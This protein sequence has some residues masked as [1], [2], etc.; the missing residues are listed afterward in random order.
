MKI[1]PVSPFKK[2][3]SAQE[4]VLCTSYFYYYA[5]R[6]KMAWA[7]SVT[8]FSHSIILSSSVSVHYLSNSCKHS[9]QILNMDISWKN[10]GQVRIWSWPID[11]WQSYSP[12]WN[13]QFPFII[14]P[15]VLHIQLKFDTRIRQRN[16]QVKFKFGHGSM[17]FGR[18]MPLYLK[19]IWNFQFPFIISPTVLHI[20]LKYDIRIPEHQRNAQVK[21]KFIHGSMIF[22][23]VM[24]LS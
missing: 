17:I 3:C 13:F 24:P 5:P 22:G 20:Q 12:W 10:T 1:L 2:K 19:I 15:T 14:S 9:T 7:Y 11:F 21:F 4:L 6:Q 8:L 23:R 18:V 16:A